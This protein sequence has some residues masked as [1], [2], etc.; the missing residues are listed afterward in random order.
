[1]CVKQAHGH[2]SG[3]NSGKL[4]QSIV[5]PSL[6]RV[7]LGLEKVASIGNHLIQLHQRESNNL[8][9]LHQR[10]TNLLPFTVMWSEI[11]IVCTQ[12]LLSWYGCISD[13]RARV[14]AEGKGIWRRMLP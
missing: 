8:V 12:P 11:S 7:G 14:Y 5:A 9:H 2:H 6:C 10:D 1:M 4:L 3:Y 13:A